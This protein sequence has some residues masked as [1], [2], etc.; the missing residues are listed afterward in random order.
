MAREVEDA[1]RGTPNQI[2]PAAAQV[3]GEAAAEPAAGTDENV[4][5]LSSARLTK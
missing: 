5:S 1:R 3:D 4:T 2:V